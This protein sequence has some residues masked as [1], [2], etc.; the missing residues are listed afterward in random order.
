MKILKIQYLDDIP[1]NHTGIIEYPN[2][3]KAWYKDGLY[4]RIDGPACEYSSGYKSWYIEG[5]LLSLNILRS[6]TETSIFLGKEKGK[7]G[8]GWLKFLTEKGI[9]EFPIIPGM[10]LINFAIINNE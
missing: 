7:Y 2:G 5:Q 10:D 4:H 1:K 8:L 9:M 3:D 6:L